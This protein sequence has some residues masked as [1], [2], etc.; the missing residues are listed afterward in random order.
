MDISPVRLMALAKEISEAYLSGG[1]PLNDSLTKISEENELS[2]PQIQRIAEIANHETNLQ[3][4]KRSE[5]RTFTFPLASAQEV[6]S[7]VRSNDMPK[8]AAL[9]II[10]ALSAPIAALEKTAEAPLS[11]ADIYPVTVDECRIRN[12]N[13]LLSKIASRIKVYKGDLRSQ[14][15]AEQEDI[16][17]TLHKIA[18]LAKEHIILNNGQLSDFLKFACGYDPDNAGLYQQVFITMKEDLMKLGAPV[19]RALIDD[20]LKMPDGTLEIVNGGH[21]L[22]IHLDTLKN[23]ISA[24]DRAS[25]RI[26]LLDTLGAAIVDQIFALKTQKDYSDY[27]EQ[28]LDNLEKKASA[29]LEDFMTFLAKEAGPFFKKHGPGLVG[30]G[31]GAGLGVGTGIAARAMGR[32]V[33][34]E[35]TKTHDEREQLEELAT[36]RKIY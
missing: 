35:L 21:I 9:D 29:G 1:V 32:G 3:L 14:L 27:M 13:L 6:T 31:L 20:D 10:E 8:I 36:R 30:F 34:K 2:V 15:M 7:R 16:E 18:A 33:G 24:E 25:R 28:T 22:A 26:K 23:K 12:V 4:L 5:D 17:H 19:D 11:P